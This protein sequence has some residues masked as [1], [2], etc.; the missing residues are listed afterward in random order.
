MG[1]VV[2]NPYSCNGLPWLKGN[3]HSHTSNS[4]GPGE[5]QAIINAYTALKYDFLML[6]DHD[7][8][9]EPKH[10]DP[11]GM[12]LIPG[13][14]VTAGGPH[15]LHVDARSLV[16]PDK[17]RQAVLDRIA[18]DGGLSIM[19]HPNWEFHFNHC[20]QEKLVAWRGYLGIEVF[21]GVVTWLEGRATATDRW[22]RLLAEGRRIWGFANDDCHRKE[23]IGV[24][25]NMVQ[26]ERGNVADILHALATGRFYASNG[27]IIDRIDADGNTITVNAKDTQRIS[28][29]SDYARRQAVV[30]DSRITYSVPE[31][32]SFHY[33]R[34]ECAGCGEKKAWTQPFF[35]E[36]E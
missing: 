30:E 18:E 5:P 12:V 26:A 23:D 4:D 31:D 13:N 34:F 33:V 11:C 28:V 36:H 21:N 32:A 6:S 27:V 9:T 1:L 35:I 29:F 15:V 3:L 8:L 17:D 7:F 22:D 24:G 19:C 14:E 2:R 10:L 20:P 16:P 25:W